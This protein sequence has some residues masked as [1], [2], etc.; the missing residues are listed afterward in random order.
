MFQPPFIGEH[1][2]RRLENR[3]RAQT[4]GK[5]QHI[6]HRARE[7]GEFW[8][9]LFTGREKKQKM[10]VEVLRRGPSF[11]AHPSSLGNF[12]FC[13]AVLQGATLA[14]GAEQAFSSRWAQ[15]FPHRA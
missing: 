6:M 13:T 10:E 15:F 2:Q 3:R 1:H 8:M 11:V 7:G 14:V 5:Q 4:N 12:S 9:E